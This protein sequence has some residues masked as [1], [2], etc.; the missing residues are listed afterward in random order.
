ML[1][2]RNLIA[3]N[4]SIFMIMCG[5]GVCF[6]Y[7]PLKMTQLSGSLS[8]AGFLASA[9]GFAYILSQY[10]IGRLADRFGFKP[11]ILSGFLLSSVSGL[12]YYYA[13]TPLYLIVG[14]VIQGIGEAPLWSL[15][16]VLL[17]LNYPG[18]KAK[19]MGW[20]TA[21]FHFGLTVGPILATPIA[22]L[23]GAE[24]TF[25]FYAGASAT[26]GLAILLTKHT[27]ADQN[28]ENSSGKSL[29]EIIRSLSKLV[30]SGITLYGACYGL[31]VSIIPAYL[32][33][34][35]NLEHSI[36]NTAFSMSFF[37]I[38]VVQIMSGRFV[39]K[40]NMIRVMILALLC[41]GSGL[42]VIVVGNGYF[43]IA[44]LLT[45]MAGLGLFSISSMLYINEKSEA[46]NAGAASGVYFT[47]WGIGYFA[48]PLFMGLIGSIQL[49]EQMMYI[50]ALVI[51]FVSF[52]LVRDFKPLF[53]R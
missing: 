5:L 53:T 35:K 30:L 22:D 8:E 17:A 29:A 52:C 39:K 47:F 21:L 6:T 19:V 2:L 51:L 44:G 37:T 31:I 7:L 25:I 48:V 36:V 28:S 26:G 45:L 40:D 33:I 27:S 10:P 43:L 38:G 1:H 15:S 34:Q 32:L 20:Y 49:T 46:G 12:I 3:V 11:I 14:R 23:Y 9:F 42:A 41:L 24:M 50:L 13:S 4:T 16:P 18:N